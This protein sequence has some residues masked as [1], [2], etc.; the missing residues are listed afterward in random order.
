[1]ENQDLISEWSLYKNGKSKFDE[2]KFLT[3][4]HEKLTESDL[5]NIFNGIPEN[6]SLLKKYKD[7][8][9]PFSQK[10]KYFNEFPFRENFIEKQEAI[11]LIKKSI[12]EK[13]KIIR[14]VND[15]ELIEIIE[16]VKQKEFSIISKEKF[17]DL[18][19]NDDTPNSWII[20]TIG[21]YF[22]A[23]NNYKEP[24]FYGLNEA[25][26][27]LTTDFQLVWYLMSPLQS[28]KY[29]SNYYYQILKSGWDYFIGEE[30]VYVSQIYS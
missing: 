2:C 20:E 3:L 7:L 28:D 23:N 26:Y 27:G 25:Y 18:L 21:D 13:E 9:S 6:E 30:V 12:L 17:N 8:F 24:F 5:D 10:E 15:E 4:F 16:R 29:N 1:M 19:L 11:E 22:S 14:L